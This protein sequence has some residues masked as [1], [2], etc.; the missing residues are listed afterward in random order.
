M[1][2]VTRHGEDQTGSLRA[3][4]MENE[5]TRDILLTSFIICPIPDLWPAGT[6]DQINDQRRYSTDLIIRPRARTSII[7]RLQS[8]L[9]LLKA[10]L[11]S[12]YL[13]TLRSS[14]LLASV[15]QGQVST[16]KAIL[17]LPC[18]DRSRMTRS[19]LCACTMTSAGIDR[20]PGPAVHPSY[21]TAQLYFCPQENGYIQGL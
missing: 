13:E 2:Q 16:T 19:G 8:H 5:H 9:S 1:R 15:S 7:Y 17:C 10:V 14:A 11:K 18:T 3:W 21:S 6:Q 12:A 20:H 4:N